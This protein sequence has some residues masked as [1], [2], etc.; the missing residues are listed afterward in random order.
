MAKDDRLVSR[1]IRSATTVHH[2]RFED[3]KHVRILEVPIQWILLLAVGTVG[4]ILMIDTNLR[5]G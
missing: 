1:M 5:I 2:W 3:G 4:Y